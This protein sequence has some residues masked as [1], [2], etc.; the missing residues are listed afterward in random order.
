MNKP[1]ESK[2]QSWLKGELEG[3]DLREMETWAENN[4]EQ[5][6]SDMG[7]DSLQTEIQTTLPKSEEPP[8]ADFF[9]ERIK[10]HTIEAPQEVIEAPKKPNF[11]Q[12]LNWLL[13]PTALAGMMVCFY[14]GTK[15]E[16]EAGV[17]PKQLVAMT[18][19]EGVY[20][21]VSGVSSAV[22]ETESSTVIMLDG[23]DDI[24][25]GLDIVAGES[26]YGVSPRMLVKAERATYYF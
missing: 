5:L 4:A 12:K 16:G 1:D 18:P 13:A 24:P 10:H 6:E 21:P 14:A 25:D 9:N 11:F 17:T 7:W 2:I 15:V 19:V 26:T 23:L 8:Y 22:V 3:N 20:T